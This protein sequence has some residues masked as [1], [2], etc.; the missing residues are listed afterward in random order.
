MFSHWLGPR[1]FRTRCIDFDAR[2][3]HAFISLGEYEGGD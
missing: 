1:A 3:E 2:N